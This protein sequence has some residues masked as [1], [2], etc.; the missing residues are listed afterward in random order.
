[1]S[2]GPG[3]VQRTIAAAFEAN[4]EKIFTSVQLAKLAYQTETPSRFQLKAIRRA[5]DPIAEGMGWVRR[6]IMGKVQYL[7]PSIVKPRPTE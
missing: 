6:S 4:P 1:M 2:T 7:H 5:A 3:R